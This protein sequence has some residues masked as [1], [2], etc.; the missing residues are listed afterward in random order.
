MDLDTGLLRAFVATAEE[1]HFGRAAGR[2]FITQQ[3]SSKRIARLEGI[4]GVRVLERTN[5]RVELTEAG[6]RFL[7]Y[8]RAVVEALDAA[9]AAAGIGGPVR[10]DVMDEHAA[11]V[12]LLRR[13]TGRDPAL[14]LE[15]T[16]RGGRRTAVDVLQAGDVDIAFGRAA[17]VPWPAEIHRRCALLE[18]LGLLVGAG[19]PLWP[20]PEVAMADLA[21]VPL[22]FPM[23][24]APQDWVT[25]VDELTAAFGVTV[26]QAGSSMG[27]DHFLDHTAENPD[28]ATFYGLDMRPPA[29]ERLHVIP[30]VAPSPVFAWAVMWRRHV[31]ESFVNRLV[32]PAPTR[33]PAD[34]W[35]PNADRAW[36]DR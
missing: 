36:L 20:V 16:A 30:I 3:A 24:G 22:R 11:A 29:D 10:V 6:E 5:R 1:H 26:D 28:T 15:T 32:E 27:F 13:A 14:R 33:I 12:G 4:L 8:A 7:P 23:H 31:P 34:A 18:P 21:D 2:L 19:H 35:L 25:F 9:A 17:A